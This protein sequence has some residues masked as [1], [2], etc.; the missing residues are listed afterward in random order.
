MADLWFVV[1]IRSVCM[2]RLNLIS[3]FKPK[4]EN[5][6]KDLSVHYIISQMLNHKSESLPGHTNISGCLM[7]PDRHTHKKNS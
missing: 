7:M 3:L 5:L 1:K 2:R 4:P 6:V